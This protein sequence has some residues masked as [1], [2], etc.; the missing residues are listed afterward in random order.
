MFHQRDY[1]LRLI[2]QFGRIMRM[3]RD[4]I[5]G[6][7]VRT[8]ETADQ[9]RKI[10]AEAGL[11]LGIARALAPESLSILVTFS[12]DVEAGRCWLLAEL[13]YLEGLQARSDGNGEDAQACFQRAQVL[14]AMLPADWRPSPDFPVVGERLEEVRNL[15][16]EG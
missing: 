16:Q 5:L 3:L 6:R 9:L 10:A 11:D 8:D 4:R 13:L 12:G 15:L 14:F 1:I 7:K 2:E